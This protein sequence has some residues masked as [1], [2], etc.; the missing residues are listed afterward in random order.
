GDQED[1]SH[2]SGNHVRLDEGPV[3]SRRAEH[4]HADT[5]QNADREDNGRQGQERTEPGRRE[6]SASEE[7]CCNQRKTEHWMQ[8]HVREVEESRLRRNGE[9]D[10]I[11]EQQDE[12][13]RNQAR[14]TWYHSVSPLKSIGPPCI[15]RHFGENWRVSVI[16]GSLALLL[17][18][19]LAVGC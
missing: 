18:C 11:Q 5:G 13:S 17:G 4:Q 10:R 3:G 12:D 15:E 1:R 9:I 2:K 7:R 6:L 16:K 19:A 8:R 14:R